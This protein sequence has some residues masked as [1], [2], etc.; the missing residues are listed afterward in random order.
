MFRMR[1]YFNKNIEEFEIDVPIAE[2][3]IPKLIEEYKK[4]YEENP[5]KEGIL[6]YELIKKTVYQEE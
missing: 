4:R 1:I 3:K 6:I 2:E 5:P